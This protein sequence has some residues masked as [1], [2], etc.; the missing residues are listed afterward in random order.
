M[1]YR[2][3]DWFYL[4]CY[5]PQAN[6][7]FLCLHHREIMLFLFLIIFSLSSGED[8][9]EKLQELERLLA[10]AQ[11]DKMRILE[12]QVCKTCVRQPLSKRPKIGFQDQLWLNAG[13]RS[14][15]QYFWHSLS[16]HLS[17][18]SLFCLFLS[19]CFTQVLLY[20][21]LIIDTVWCH[22]FEWSAVAQLQ[23]CHGQGKNS[24]KWKFFEFSEKSGNFIFSWGNLEKKMKK[25]GE[26]QNFPKKFTL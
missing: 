6:P 22:I 20:V 9:I 16:Y 10:Q 26:F 18:R 25:V 11:H 7:R 15:L 5:M 14:I 13:Q 23:G 21:T 3:L 8:Q 24:G 12:D 1:V 17:L 4:G 2:I 19:G